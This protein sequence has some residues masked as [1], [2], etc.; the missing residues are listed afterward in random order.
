MTAPFDIVAFLRTLEQALRAGFSLRQAL[1][2]AAQDFDSNHLRDVAERAASSAPLATLF[3]DWSIVEPD[4]GLLAGAVRLQ[5]EVEGNLADVLGV[6]H[7]VL[8]RRSPSTLQ[9]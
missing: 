8:A 9:R 1:E 4:I 6:L 2:R 5:M 7:A 3:D